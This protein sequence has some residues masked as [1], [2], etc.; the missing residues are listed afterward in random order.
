MIY[1]HMSWSIIFTLDDFDT[2]LYCSILPCKGIA[3]CLQEKVTC[4]N[5]ANQQMCSRV[6]VLQ[7]SSTFVSLMNALI[8]GL[9]VRDPATQ[10]CV[11]L[12]LSIA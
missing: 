12:W 11:E 10:Y 8:H 2:L 7:L 1:L 3:C 9:V 6:S 4:G 5:A